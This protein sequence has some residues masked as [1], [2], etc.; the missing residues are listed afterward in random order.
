MT[1]W[2]KHILKQ[3][4]ATFLFLLACLFVIYVIVDLSAHGV[5]FLSKSGFSEIALYYLYTFAT[6]LELFLTLAF[7]LST[8]RILFD[9]SSHRELLALQMAGLSKKK[10]LTPFFLFAT[11]L[12]LVSYVNGQWLGPDAQQ[13]T[14]SFKISY[15]PKKNKSDRIHVH[16]IVLEDKSELVYRNYNKEKKELFDVFW[17][18]KPD[19]IW[20]MKYLEIS[21]IKGRYVNHL[22]RGQNK[23]FEKSESFVEHFFADLPWN[24]EVLLHRVIPLESRPLSMLLVQAFADSAENRSLLSHLYYKL[25]VPLMPF[26]VLIAIAPIAMRYSRNQPLFLIVATSIFGLIALKVIL[27]GM[28]ILGENQVLPATVAILGP[29]A[30]VLALSIPS[31]VKM[32]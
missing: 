3:L 20:H 7:L 15:K 29:V 14:E 9:L 1:I 25:L 27:D 17:V 24:E 26:L 32:R 31:F 8:I 28:L 22:V 12:S 21:P 5:R 10:L 30:L 18:R 4:V 16:S 23:Q 2:Q 11:A 6:L 19:D 13:V